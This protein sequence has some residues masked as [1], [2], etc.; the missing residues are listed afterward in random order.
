MS[1]YARAIASLGRSLLSTIFIVIA[2][3]Q[4][5]YWEQADND[6]SYALANWEIYAGDA[7]HIGM[8]FTDMVTMVPVLLV[9][10]IVLQLLGGVFLFFSY[11]V[12]FASFLLLIY[13]FCDTVVYHPFWYM[14]GPALSRSLVLFLKN[15][16]IFGGLLIVLAMG[17]GYHKMN[18]VRHKR[19]V[20]S[21]EQDEDDEY[22][23]E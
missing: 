20:H 14:D 5:F 10:G 17:K 7:D 19:R 11:R 9:I 13:L 8:F 16:A 23:D 12:R 1:I 15:L 3:S 21:R 6:L 2:L 18:H 4:I 22:D